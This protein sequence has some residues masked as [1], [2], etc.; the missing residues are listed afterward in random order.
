MFVTFAINAINVHTGA[1]IMH[2]YKYNKE[3]NTF[4]SIMLVER[5]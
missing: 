5:M 2:V 1:Y 4:P 3:K